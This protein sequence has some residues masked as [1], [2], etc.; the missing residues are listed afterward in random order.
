MTEEGV[1]K[2]KRCETIFYRILDNTG[3]IDQNLNGL[4]SE[5]KTKTNL[6]SQLDSTLLSL[7]KK[8]KES[9]QVVKETFDTALDLEKRSSNLEESMNSLIK[10]ISGQSKAA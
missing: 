9:E 3:F 1:E 8:T 2:A 10:N 4:K 7:E 6:L 5:S